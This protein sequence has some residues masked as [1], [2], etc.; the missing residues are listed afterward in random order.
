MRCIGNTF[1]H[2]SNPTND[3]APTTCRHTGSIWAF[4]QFEEEA[5]AACEEECLNDLEN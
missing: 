3:E 1:P 4:V 5:E 2:F